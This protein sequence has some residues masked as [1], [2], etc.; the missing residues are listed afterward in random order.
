MFA[1]IEQ[2]VVVGVSGYKFADSVL[3]P[4]QAKTGDNW[5][6]ENITPR[7]LNS[8]ELKMIGIE[9]EGVM[10][11][12]LSEDMWGLGSVKDWVKSGGETNFRFR[13]GNKLKL[14]PSNIEAFEAVWV[15]FRVSFFS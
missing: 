10:C 1:K 11:S 12:A 13:N 6:G 15:P 4:D 7:S 3:V 14:K 9:F 5:D 8:D 2:G